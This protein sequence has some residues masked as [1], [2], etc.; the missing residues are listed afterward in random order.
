MGE[1]PES[2]IRSVLPANG[3]SCS[4]TSFCPT[5]SRRV[6]TALALPSQRLPA[7]QDPDADR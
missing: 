6:E 5:I 7:Q 2:C 3:E 1:E 4:V